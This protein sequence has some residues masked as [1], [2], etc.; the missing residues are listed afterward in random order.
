PKLLAEFVGQQQARENLSVFIQAARS[1][2]EALDHVL[3]SGPPGLGKTTLAQIVAR[4][5]GVGF[6]STSGPVLAKAGDLAAI[7]TNLE[8]RDVLFID[9]I[10]R[11]NPAV[12]EIL[13]PAMEDF[14]LDLV[15]GE[16]PSARS[17]KIAL[18]PFT[19][20][21][22]TT[23]AGLITTPLRDRFGIPLRLNF[24]T[25][26]ELLL[27]V[28]RGARVLGFELTDDGAREIAGRARGTPRIAG[29]LLKRVRDFASVA[30]QGR[31]DAKVADHALTRLEVDARGL[32][33]FDMRYLRLIAEQFSGGPVGIE[34]I[35]AALG[36]ARDA[37]EEV[38]EPFLMQQ[39]FVQRTPRGRLLT[40]AAYGHIGLAIPPRDP[41]QT[42]LFPENGED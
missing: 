21:G 34:T 3:F 22:A 32:D 17:V 1:R 25:P 9:E 15:I 27:I 13:Y 33:A 37:I 10:H 39:G 35:A 28:A 4:E 18:Q 19:L 38:I 29:R 20:V 5:L 24:Y 41:A 7:L 11:L 12:E 2:A 14:E 42:G 31:V 40:A 8:A 36:E 16:G 6:R 26:D 23:R 30:G